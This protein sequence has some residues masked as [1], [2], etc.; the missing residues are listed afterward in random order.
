LRNS[1]AAYG[2]IYH[3]FEIR[4]CGGYGRVAAVEGVLLK[5]Q[6]TAGKWSSAFRNKAIKTLFGLFSSI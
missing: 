4:M 6:V 5:N 2:E 1:G 3:D